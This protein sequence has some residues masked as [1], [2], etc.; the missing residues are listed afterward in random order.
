MSLSSEFRA[1]RTR[2]N[3]ENILGHRLIR[4]GGGTAG[5]G[6]FLVKSTSAWNKQAP[7]N[8]RAS[9]KRQDYSLLH[10]SEQLRTRLNKALLGGC[11]STSRFVGQADL[12]PTHLQGNKSDGS[13][14]NLFLELLGSRSKKR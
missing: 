6:T 3:L 10:I 8:E 4:E 12:F 13:Q 7:F 11:C 1:G 5:V 14:K 2:L 9:S